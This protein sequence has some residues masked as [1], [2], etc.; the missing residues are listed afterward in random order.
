MNIKHLIFNICVLT[1]L[2]YSVLY[3]TTKPSL[4]TQNAA[5]QRI[6]D[7]NLSQFS[8]TQY[9]TSG[10]TNF[11]IKGTSLKHFSDNTAMLETISGTLFVNPRNVVNSWNIKANKGTIDLDSENLHIF[12]NVEVQQ[13]SDHKAFSPVTL[14]TEELNIDK[15]EQIIETD[16]SISINAVSGEI[17]GVGFYADLQKQRLRIKSQV[18]SRYETP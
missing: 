13:I 9:A 14:R 8:V 17:T 15:S 5:Q 11:T 10:D 1:F 2:G 6:E 7:Y 3:I 12:D 4:K 16:A 18:K